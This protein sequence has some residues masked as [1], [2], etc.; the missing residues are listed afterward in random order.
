MEEQIKTINENQ[1]KRERVLIIGD[2]KIDLTKWVDINEVKKSVTLKIILEFYGITPVRKI[3]EDQYIAVSPFCEDKNKPSLSYN[4][5]MN[6]FYCF[7]S[8]IKG[9][10]FDFV[11][12][13]NPDIKDLRTAALFIDQVI[14]GYKTIKQIDNL[15]DDVYSVGNFTPVP[16]ETLHLF[17]LK[18]Y[19]DSARNFTLTY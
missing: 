12:A 6:A 13:M 14:R 18:S 2:Y 8:K 19:T 9:N 10:I 16:S 17:R 4:V 11:M 7:E 15:G 5:I 3:K 1:P